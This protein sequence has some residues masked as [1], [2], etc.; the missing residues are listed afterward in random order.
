MRSAVSRR[1]LLGLWASFLL[2]AI[3]PA[4]HCPPANARATFAF[5]ASAP[6]TTAGQASVE[7]IGPLGVV[8][9]IRDPDPSRANQ[10]GQEILRHLNDLLDEGIVGDSLSATFGAQ[11]ARILRGNQVILTITASDAAAN[12]TTVEALCQTWLARLRE[13]F[14]VPYFAIPAAS[15]MVPLGGEMAVPLRGPLAGEVVLASATPE[16]LEAS[17]IGPTVLVLRGTAEGEALA[18]FAADHGP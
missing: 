7:V 6:S 14:N 9:R 17:R 11:G 15:L 13:A 12:A 10:R 1:R 8:L 16:I 5:V 4:V 2:A 18:N 3:V